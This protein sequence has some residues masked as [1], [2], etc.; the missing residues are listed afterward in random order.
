[1]TGADAAPIPSL[2]TERGRPL[3]PPPELLRLRDRHG[4][5]CPL[6][7]PDG[8]IGW[9]VTGD[10]LARAVLGDSRFSARSEFKRVPILRPGADPFIGQPALPGWFVDM[11][12]PDHTR[13]RRLVAGHLGVRRMEELRPLAEQI[14][15][16]QLNA[17]EQQGGPVDLVEAFAL[18]VP[19][20]M[21]CELL[22]VPPSERADL[23]RYSEI[24]FSL[25]ATADDGIHAMEELSRLIRDLVRRKRMVP[26][27]DLLTHLV[28]SGE[29]DDEEATGAGVLLV[30]A[31]H[32]TVTSMLGLGTFA[33][34]CHPEAWAALC[35]DPSMVD[36][37]VEELLRY[38]TIFHF[39]VPRAP[40]EDV[41]L[42]GQL[43]RAGET[44]TISLPAANRDGERYVYPD[45][46]DV[47]RAAVGHLAFGFGAHQCVGQNLARMELR[48]GYRGLLRR[49]PQLQLAVPAAHVQTTHGGFYGVRRL[50]VTW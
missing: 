36:G 3:D 41:E 25:D 21:I 23:H 39:G 27:G 40:L 13:F 18:P 14:V 22:G 2:P 6:A 34:L 15:E 16:D 42:A 33:L 31:G 9:L 37:S 49:F 50:P 30:T 48:A 28:Q 7:Y 4:P 5:L 24:L 46:F 20:L 8:H 45:E 19:S 11:D 43:I 38:L 35:A 44:V 17:M 47:A 29:V 10:G 1:M 26:E 32:E 12:R